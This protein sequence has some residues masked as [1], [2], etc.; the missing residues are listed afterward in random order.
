MRIKQISFASIVLLI[1][2][3]NAYAELPNHPM[4]RNCIQNFFGRTACFPEGQSF[5]QTLLNREINTD[6][7]E[8]F[9]QFMQKFSAIGRENTQ[10]NWLHEQQGE[11]N[12]IVIFT[13]SKNR[14]EFRSGSRSLGWRNL[15][16]IP[17]I[18]G[19]WCEQ[20][21][22][23]NIVRKVTQLVETFHP[24]QEAIRNLEASWRQME[25]LTVGERVSTVCPEYG[26]G[27]V[28]RPYDEHLPIRDNV[29]SCFDR[30]MDQVITYLE[31]SNEPEQNIRYHMQQL[32]NKG[33]RI[34]LVFPN[35]ENQLNHREALL[36]FH[37]SEI[38]SEIISLAN[39][40]WRDSIPVSASHKLRSWSITNNI[41]SFFLR[42]ALRYQSMFQST[43]PSYP[44]RRE[45]ENFERQRRVHPSLDLGLDDISEKSISKKKT[46]TKNGASNKT[47][48]P[49]GTVKTLENVTEN[50]FNIIPL[51]DDEYEE[52][53]DGQIVNND[54]EL[55]DEDT[56]DELIEDEV[57]NGN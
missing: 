13:G 56:F 17:S 36:T 35:E 39:Y 22:S 45:S 54:L 25:Q 15:I 3:I 12:L 33:F 48:S 26:T 1:T 37:N 20:R 38:D 19:R 18:E 24:R 52:V 55:P 28:E 53:E 46:K 44:P 6:D 2:I 23:N 9:R 4:V 40:L 51:N 16:I 11:S 47:P 32:C 43:F 41:D 14:P 34:E 49:P 27:V 42:L 21:L 50:E 29:P 7:E 10:G 8:C 5:H 57:V 30:T 31:E